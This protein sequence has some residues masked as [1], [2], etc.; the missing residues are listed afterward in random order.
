MKIK[1]VRG[2][3]CPPLK[4]IFNVSYED[5]PARLRK[6]VDIEEGLRGLGRY[7]YTP[8]LKYITW[9]GFSTEH[10]LQR[11][12]LVYKIE[13]RDYKYITFKEIR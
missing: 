9:G 4:L 13:G 5:L 10:T 8:C 12:T 11:Y 2:K 7:H 3:D 6:A 1:G